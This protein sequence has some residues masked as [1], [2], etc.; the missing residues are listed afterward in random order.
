MY[1]ARAF[2][3]MYGQTDGSLRTTYSSYLYRHVKLYNDNSK[4]RKG[5]MKSNHRPKVA[6]ES[7]PLNFPDRKETE[8]KFEKVERESKRER[9]RITATQAKVPRLSFAAI[10]LSDSFLSR[11]SDRN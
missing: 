9:E 6:A 5:R 10:P 7:S 2:V 11:E 1:N 3:E 4:K 8:R